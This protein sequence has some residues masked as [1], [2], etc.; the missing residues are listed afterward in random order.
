[1]LS[2]LRTIDRSRGLAPDN[3]LGEG[4]TGA[5]AFQLDRTGLE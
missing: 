4:G 2:G 1:V 5:T 3:P